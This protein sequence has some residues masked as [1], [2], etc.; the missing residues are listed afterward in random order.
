[1]S[2]GLA[3]LKKL[4]SNPNIYKE[5]EVKAEVLMSGFATIAKENNIPFAYNVRGSMFGFFFNEK[6][7]KNFDDVCN[8]DEAR[9]AKFH[10]KMLEKGFYF[11]PSAYETGFICTAM[12]D[13]DIE[14]TIEAFDKIVKEL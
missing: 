10:S 6:Q 13:K 11:A 2:A 5:L 3:S 7:P 9:Y 12:N 1:M 8:G 4:K 14:A